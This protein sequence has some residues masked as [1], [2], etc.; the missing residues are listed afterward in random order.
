[1]VLR[2]LNGATVENKGWELAMGY[3]DNLDNGL[4]YTISTNFGAFKDKITALPEEVRTGF[5][6]NAEQDILGQSQFA[7]FG[8]SANGLFQNQAEVDA[9]ATQVGAA[10]GRIRYV[11]LNN[12]GVVNALDQEFFG[13]T[14]PS[15]EYGLSINLGYRNFDLSL[16]GSG[17]AGRRGFD[18]YIFLNEFIRGREN[19]GPGTLDAWTPQNTGSTIPALTLS[20]GNNETRASNY[21]FVNN[22]Y[23]KLR[24]FSLGYS[25]SERI[26]N[27]LGPVSAFRMYVQVENLFWI[28][29]NEFKGPD[30]ERTN[31]SAIPVPTV[32]SL[33]L[34]VSL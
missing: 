8:F 23:F 33:G 7:I 25:L 30:P 14:L 28:K 5:A 32:L 12:D 21:L 27:N 9:H 22:S 20:D 18:N 34:N 17:V 11:D 16:F 15:L 13:T 26:L 3:T 24:N 31:M 2:T 6:G 10:P 4:T 1:G 19:V 29:S